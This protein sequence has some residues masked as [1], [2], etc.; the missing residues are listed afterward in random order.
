MRTPVLAVQPGN[1]LYAVFEAGRRLD[2]AGEGVADLHA[3]V[4]VDNDGLPTV[5]DDA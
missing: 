3:P 5:D 1:H 2:R 4:T